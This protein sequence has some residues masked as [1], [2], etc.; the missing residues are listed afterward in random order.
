MWVRDPTPQSCPL[1]YTGTLWHTCAYHTLY[2]HSNKNPT[3]AFPIQPRW[4]Y[5]LRWPMLTWTL[6]SSP[7]AFT[8]RYSKHGCFELA[9]GSK[10]DF[11]HARQ[12]SF[13]Q[14]CY[15]CF[16][17]DLSLIKDWDADLLN[18]NNNKQNVVSYLSLSITKFYK[19]AHLRRKLIKF[20]D[21]IKTL[22][23][24][25][26]NEASFMHTVTTANLTIY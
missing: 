15:S 2:T 23:I 19:N 11:V 9:R 12:A 14:E 6:T 3:N 5:K 20:S 1:A 17:Q 26:T 24:C 18:N 8:T 22:K 7:P 16:P 13:Y 4:L 10:L 25:T 21:C